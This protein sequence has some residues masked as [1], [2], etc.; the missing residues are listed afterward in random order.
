M[1][2]VEQHAM[3]IFNFVFTCIIH[4][5]STILPQNAIIESMMDVRNCD[6]WRFARGGWQLLEVAEQEHVDRAI[7]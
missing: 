3:K 5:D 6:E 7:P 2:D 4:N 1:R